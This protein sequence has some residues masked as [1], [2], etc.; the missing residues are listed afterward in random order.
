[1]KALKLKTLRLLNEQKGFEI[2]RREGMATRNGIER[3]Y[4]DFAVIDFE[5]KRL[6]QKAIVLFLNGCVEGP[7]FEEVLRRLDLA[8]TSRESSDS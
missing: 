3:T 5:K 1:M 8:S 7:Y 6:L 2:S 4:V